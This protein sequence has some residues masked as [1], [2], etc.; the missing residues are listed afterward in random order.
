[1]YEGTCPQAP[2][3][4]LYGVWR[5]TIRTLSSVA[6]VIVDIERRLVRLAEGHDLLRS[7]RWVLGGFMSALAVRLGQDGDRT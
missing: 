7:R 1:M 4:T 5:G 2:S 3:Y 6:G